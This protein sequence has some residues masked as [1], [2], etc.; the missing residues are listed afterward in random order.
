MTKDKKLFAAWLEEQNIDVMSVTGGPRGTLKVSMPAGSGDRERI[1]HEYGGRGVVVTFFDPLT[2]PRLGVSPALPET[3]HRVREA[4][5]KGGGWVAK[6]KCE[7]GR[8][9]VYGAELLTEVG[10]GRVMCEECKG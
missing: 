10:K 4:S 9:V 2:V 1:P 5:F 8:G 3:V 6:W 7:R